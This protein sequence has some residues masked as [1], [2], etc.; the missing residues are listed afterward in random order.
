MTQTGQTGTILGTFGKSGKL[1]VRLNTEI[2]ADI[3]E[4]QTQLLNT[5]VTL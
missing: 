1:K 5:E 3:M 2:P 4:D